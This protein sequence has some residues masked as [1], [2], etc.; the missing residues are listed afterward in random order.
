MV[1]VDDERGCGVVCT[2]QLGTL[3]AYDQAAGESFRW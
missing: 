2:G 3:W 1:E